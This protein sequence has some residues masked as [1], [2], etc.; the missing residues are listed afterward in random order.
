LAGLLDPDRT[1]I[2]RS[3]WWRILAECDQPSS[4]L[5][6]ATVPCEILSGFLVFC[7]RGVSRCF[8]LILANP[9]KQPRM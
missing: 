1:Q 4:A 6:L 5:F 9:E 3:G 2:R 8:C 7:D